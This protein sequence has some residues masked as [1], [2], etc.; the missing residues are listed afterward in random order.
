MFKETCCSNVDRSNL[1]DLCQNGP[2]RKHTLKTARNTLNNNSEI[3]NIT[4][5]LW[6]YIDQPGS[7][8]NVLGPNLKAEVLIRWW[9]C[10]A[11]PY[12]VLGPK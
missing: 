6:H 4:E 5:A 2:Y 1:W 7:S 3:V 11:G 12:N 8:T 10:L 9:G